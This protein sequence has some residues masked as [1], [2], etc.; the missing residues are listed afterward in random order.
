MS[1]IQ[2]WNRSYRCDVIAVQECEQE[3]GYEEL[4]VSHDLAGSVE[5]VATRGHV[6]V[7]VRRGLPYERVGMASGAPCVA[8]RLRV[9]EG[10]GE[11]AQD[12]A[13]VAAHLPTGDSAGRRERIIVEAVRA[14]GAGGERLVVIGDLNV[15]D[16]GEVE[17]LCHA[18]DLHEARYAGFSWGVRGN[19]FYADSGYAGPGLRKDR[20]LFGSRTWAEAHL[21]GQGKMFFEGCEF[22]LSDHF[23]VMAYV[24]V[25]KVYA[26]K[27][28]QDCV[29]ARVRRGQLVSMRD[30]A[31]QKE[32]LEVKAS[33]QA[34]REGQALAQRRAAERERAEYQR[35]QERGARQR[36]ERRVALRR[37]AF[38]PDGLFAV[39]ESVPALG[40]IT[41]CSP[42]EVLIPA[43]DDVPFGSWETTKDVPLRGMRNVGNT[44]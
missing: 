36:R 14:V 5:A 34:G 9:G 41:P 43:L 2:R 23:G 6:H 20:V 11:A 27:A 33:G 39:V 22:G 42:T 21:V 30:E 16:D 35:A 17:S 13:V 40:P 31:Q 28:K 44:C 8:V 3:A 32:L 1:E 24:D 7:Y 38:G 12:C 15:K 26:S 25:D 10:V 19:A 29:T 18:L 37:A 4:L